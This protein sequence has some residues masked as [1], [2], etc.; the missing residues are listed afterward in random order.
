MRV[1][2]K[3]INGTKSGKLVISL[4]CLGLAYLFVSLSINYGN[5]LY[6]LAAL[7]SMIYFLKYLFSLI[8]GMIHGFDK[9]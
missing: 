3:R 5:L 9:R 8:K 4:A 7:I 1:D 6:Y 2:L